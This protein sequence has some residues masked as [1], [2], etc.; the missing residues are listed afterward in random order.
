MQRN[1]QSGS[2]LIYSLVLVVI[3]V[4]M[5]TVILSSVTRLTLNLDFIEKSHTFNKIL[6]DDS[7]RLFDLARKFNGNG[8][9][10]IDTLTCPTFTM[11]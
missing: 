8:T 4:L 11:S 5:A 3:V 7:T 2:V 10:F 9:G 6:T 1:R